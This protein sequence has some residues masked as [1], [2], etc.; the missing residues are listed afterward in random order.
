[1]A[2]MLGLFPEANILLRGKFRSTPAPA[3]FFTTDGIV[4]SMNAARRRVRQ[5]SLK[6][7]FLASSSSSAAQLADALLLELHRWSTGER[8]RAPGR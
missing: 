4:E 3:S 1:M 2:L 5:I 8:E 6:R 7:N